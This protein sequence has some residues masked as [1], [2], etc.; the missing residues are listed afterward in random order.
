MRK[1]P[2]AGDLRFTRLSEGG[3]GHGFAYRERATHPRRF[4]ILGRPA[5]RNRAARNG[6]YS[7]DTVAMVSQRDTS[8]E[9]IKARARAALLLAVER[10]H[11]TLADNANELTLNELSQATNALGRISGIAEEERDGTVTI[12][13]IRDDAVPLVSPV[14]ATSDSDTASP[15]LLAEAQS[16]EAQVVDADEV[17]R[18]GGDGEGDGVPSGFRDE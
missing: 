17:A 8:A 14:S 4:A 12:R 6:A 13:V 10:T 2:E 18:D 11:D 3:T 16:V 15:R 1:K 7:I 5:Q 9:A